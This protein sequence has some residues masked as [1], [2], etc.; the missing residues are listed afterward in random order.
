MTGQ[1]YYNRGGGA[2]GNTEAA[3]KPVKDLAKLF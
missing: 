3:P 1:S 2:L